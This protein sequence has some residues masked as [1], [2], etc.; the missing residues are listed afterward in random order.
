MRS[1]DCMRVCPKR[2][3]FEDVGKRI[4]V[5]NTASETNRSSFEQ[6]K[7]RAFVRATQ[8]AAARR[9]VQKAVLIVRACYSNSVDACLT[10][11]LS[12]LPSG[13]QVESVKEGPCLQH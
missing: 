9:T 6:R 8:Q 5:G 7:E 4:E 10:N 12:E 11:L 13:S 3:L 1:V 2:Q